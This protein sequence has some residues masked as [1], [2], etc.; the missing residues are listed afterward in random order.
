M[1]NISPQSWHALF[2]MI[3]FS[4]IILSVFGGVALVMWTGSP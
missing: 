4:L 2:V 3:G 1:K